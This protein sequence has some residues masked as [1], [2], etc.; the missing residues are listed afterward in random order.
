MGLSRVEDILEGDYTGRPLSR[1][2]ALLLEGGGGGGGPKPEDDLSNN[3]VE[4]IIDAVGTDTD[5]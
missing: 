1:V 2:E 3:D 5:D 4:D